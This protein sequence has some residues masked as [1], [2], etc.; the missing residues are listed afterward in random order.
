M[1]FS[2][3]QSLRTVPVELE[4][5]SRSFRLSAWM[6][7]WPFGGTIRAPGVAVERHA[8][9]GRW[10]VFYR[11]S[12]SN[13]VGST[14]ITLPGIGSYVA[15]AIQ[16][17]NLKAIGWAIV[18]MFIVILACDQLIF[19]PLVAWADRFR[20][21]QEAGSWVAEPWA[22]TMMRR[23]RI[24][25]SVTWAFYGLVRFSNVA[26]PP[27]PNGEPKAHSQSATRYLRH[28]GVCIVACGG[29]VGCHG[30]LFLACSKT[31]RGKS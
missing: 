31:H 16:Q 30:R 12:G 27:K 21:E 7:F 9:H 2:F 5:V 22:L 23:S 14:T 25:Q 24:V 17:G 10:M 3:Y 26:F 1:A 11:R 8:V 18:S 20:I 15:L 29:C 28:G 13:A 4:E 19:R 6:R